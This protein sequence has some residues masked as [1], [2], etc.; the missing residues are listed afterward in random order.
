MLKTDNRLDFCNREFDAYCNS[1]CILRHKTIRNTPQQNRVAERMNRTLLEK[2]RCLLFISGM[3]KSFWGEALATASHL[4]NR[5]PSTM[6][7][8][9]YPE[10]IWT[11]KKVTLN[12]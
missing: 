2:V 1:Q 12:T 5:S 8:F 9:K 4:I 10:E 3:A 11:G 7:N 6:L